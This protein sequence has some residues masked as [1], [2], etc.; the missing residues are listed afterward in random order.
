MWLWLRLRLQ[1]K[2]IIRM[3]N[4]IS[5]YFKGKD[6]L[7][8]CTFC[9]FLCMCVSQA[10]WLC[11][12][13]FLFDFSNM[14][15]VKWSEVKWNRLWNANIVYRTEVYRISICKCLLVMM[16]IVRR[17][18]KHRDMVFFCQAIRRA[19]VSLIYMQHT[20]VRWSK[21]IVLY[22]YIRQDSKA[23]IMLKITTYRF[24]FVVWSPTVWQYEWRTYDDRIT[25]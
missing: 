1:W 2:W 10:T 13:C 23:T 15:K 18:E 21:R 16:R 12:V 20:C 6:F 9:R 7:S 25:A 17:R 24:D 14:N 22:M 8:R 5:D 4:E 11:Q 3:G 19:I